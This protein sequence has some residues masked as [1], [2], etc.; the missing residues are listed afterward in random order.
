MYQKHVPIQ[1]TL[2][3]AIAVGVSM[4]TLTLAANSPEGCLRTVLK[5]TQGYAQKRANNLRKCNDALLKD[6][7]AAAGCPVTDPKA[8][9]SGKIA[10]DAAKAKAKIE[11]KCDDAAQSGIVNC[12]RAAC[13]ASLSTAGDLADCVICNVD[14]MTDQIQDQIYGSIKDPNADKATFNCQRTFGK[15]LVKAY[16]KLSKI[17]Q[18]CEDGI[19]K[20]KISSCP[21]SKSLDKISKTITSL[22]DKLS[23]KCPMAVQDDAVDDFL[24]LTR[25]GGISGS[26]ERIDAAAQVPA[27]FPVFGATCGDADIDPGE[28]CDD[29]NLVEED[30]TGPLDTCPADCSIAACSPS[31]AG[32]ATVSIASPG[33]EF[34]TSATIVVNYDDTVLSIPGSGGGVSVT[35]LNGFSVTPADADYALRAIVLDASLFGLDTGAVLEF[36]YDQCGGTASAGDFSCFVLDAADDSFAPVEGVTCSVAP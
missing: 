13:A 23:G 7:S 21:D 2:L 29:G 12:P 24:A 31:G 16:R 28:T 3:A 25:L 34:I 9:A 5:E 4:P 36:D 26:D 22:N 15:E 33:G 6:G 1:I 30:G 19:I 27:A 18:K 8:K 10:N 17:Y 32:T 35:G 14:V 11:K 20:G